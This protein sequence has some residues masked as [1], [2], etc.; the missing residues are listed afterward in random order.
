MAKRGKRWLMTGGLVGLSALLVVLVWQPGL[1][2][3]LPSVASIRG[4]ALAP[5]SMILDR[6]GRLLYEVVD[7]HAGPHRPLRLEE[8]PL[9]LRQAVIATED[10]S[11]Y[12]NP[13]LDLRAIARALWINLRSGQTVSGGSTITQQLARNLL[14]GSQERYQRTWSRKL[15]EA[16]LAYHMTRSMSKDEILALYLNEIYFGNMAYGVE[17]AAR[18]YFG[19]PVSQLDLAECSMLAGL[20][21]AP[22]AYNPLTNLPAARARQSVVLGLM[23]KA[24]YVE[25]EQAELARQEPLQFAAAPFGI[26]APHFCMLVRDELAQ[27]LGEDALRRGGLRVHTTLDLGLQHAAEAHVK[28]HLSQL[29]QETRESPGHNVHN[30]AVVV[31]DHGDG[32][33][34]AMVGS[35]DYFDG[36]IS[37]AV[38]AVLALRQPGSAIKPLTY[39]AA[40]GQ[41]Y[42]PATVM[43]DVRSSFLTREGTLYV[44][45]NYD[46][47]YHGPVTLRRALACSYNVIAVKLLDEIGIEP[48]VTT[49]H[50][51]G[52]TTLD[53]V[54]RQGLALTLGG[55]E[56]RLLELSAAFGCFGNGGERV[57]P[58]CIDYV[59]DSQGQVI[60]RSETG[61]P[62]RV[63][64]P[65]VAYLVTD[66]LSD[67]R[68]RVPA[69]GQGS[70]LEMPFP[71]AV[72]TGTTTDWRDNWTVGYSSELVTGVW[73][74]N[75]DN[76]SMIAVSG[77]SGAA[78]IW[79]AV[80]N[81][82][83]AHRPGPFIRPPGLVEVEVCA[84]SGQLPGV[85]CVHRRKE[86]FLA[87]HVP[88]ATCRMHRLVPFDAAT[89][90]VATRDCPSERRV[91]RRVTFW[92][93]ESLAWA[94]E[95]GL[96]LPP[97]SSEGPAAPPGPADA[98]EE[99]KVA[100]LA[101]M[102]S[103]DVD[104]GLYLVSPYPHSAYAIAPD[105]PLDH[106]CIEVAAVCAPELGLKEVSLWVDGE[107]W[108][109]WLALP[110][111]VFWPL[112]P[113]VHVFEVQGVN[114][115]GRRVDGPPVHITVGRATAIGRR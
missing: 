26:E 89:G 67:R 45:I 54:E 40:F 15:R 48:M 58:R 102:A 103:K 95:Q 18:A 30:A 1:L 98:E 66:V 55:C 19:K 44:P 38:N 104:S 70:A 53:Q 35:P 31:L 6:N 21:Q 99:P 37:G 74:G 25:P 22:E 101:S 96:P 93:R 68:A 42:A 111:R 57:V 23:V 49:A 7:P 94:E 32:S 50:K 8:I 39:A 92:P 3:P 65:R 97:S 88:T 47:R 52:I 10:L 11:F 43:S 36:E 106:Q 14:L 46:Y 13:G 27:R 4:R 20:P 63:L 17:A 105:I 51:L 87:E 84:E 79:H 64:D 72:K 5:S 100:S 114:A 62:E 80:M 110:Y 115:E 90:Q 85:A 59:E 81:S 41:G 91:Y 16:V 28:R 109:T 113:G 77:I 9:S 2:L 34:L 71:A 112:S 24:G 75:A 69:F 29:N 78:P 56:V 61:Q 108:H 83:H 60:Y 33:V 73:V 12:R 86:L 76:Q 107:R 82:A